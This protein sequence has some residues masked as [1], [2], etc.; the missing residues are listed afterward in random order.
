LP[1]I[2]DE[3]PLPL[4]DPSGRCP[5]EGCGEQPGYE[6]LLQILADPNDAERDAT[7]IW[8]GG[9]FDPTR[10]DIPIL[11]ATVDIL[12]RRWTPRGRA[13]PKVKP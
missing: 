5:P 2:E 4:L 7:L 13:A 8:C 6:R 12:A 1:T 3:R 9:A 11:E 10:A